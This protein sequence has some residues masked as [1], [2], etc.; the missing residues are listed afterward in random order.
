MAGIKIWIGFLLLSTVGFS[1]EQPSALYL[2]RSTG[3]TAAEYSFSTFVN[4]TLVC[5]LNN[6]MFAVHPV[7]PGHKT[8][9][10]QYGGSNPKE[11]AVHASLTVEP[12]RIYFFKIGVQQ[13]FGG[14][15]IVCT[16]LL[17]AD[18]RNLLKTLKADSKCR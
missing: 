18:A 5:K 8:I 13:R 2:M 17:P 6:L 15:D 10:V 12:G 16:Q 4:D 14:C 9:L 1:Q 7:S 11:K 3:K